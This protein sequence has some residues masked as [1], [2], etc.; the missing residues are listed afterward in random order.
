[1]S[2]AFLPNLTGCWWHCVLQLVFE[3]R[4]DAANE[5]HA[6]EL[7]QRELEKYKKQ[8]IMAV[9]E[10]KET[11]VYYLRELSPVDQDKL[12]RPRLHAGAWARALND[13]LDHLFVGT[14]GSSL[15]QLCARHGVGSPANAFV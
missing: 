14:D 2:A 8:K 15:N 3:A 4:Q 7:Q 1:M 11:A 13:D 10:Y 9:L 6:L 5:D 12:A